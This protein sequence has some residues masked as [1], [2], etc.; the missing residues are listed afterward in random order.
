MPW[1]KSCDIFKLNTSPSVNTTNTDTKA[2]YSHIYLILY[3]FVGDTNKKN[4]L[5]TQFFLDTAFE[6]NNT[7]AVSGEKLELLGQTIFKISFDIAGNYQVN[8]SA[9]VSTKDGCK[10]NLLRM[11]F[12]ENSVR[13]IDICSPKNDLTKF[14]VVSLML[15]RNQTESYPC[16]SSYK[17]CNS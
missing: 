4:G 7:L 1:T 12:I 9:W 16:V 2:I 8:V 5:E 14:P 13:S 17:N 15:S 11:D 3:Q 6:K 10:P